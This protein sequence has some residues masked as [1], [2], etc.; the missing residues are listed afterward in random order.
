[1][2]A[3]VVLI[4]RILMIVSIYGFLGLAFLALWRE[5]KKTTEQQA[6]N[7]QPSL[8]LIIDGSENLQFSQPE[9]FIGRSANNDIQVIDETVSQHHARIFFQYD[10]WMLEDSR[11][12]NG[13]FLN[14]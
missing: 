7:A 8:S 5:L 12:T 14:G 4:I 10:H 11:S 9:I 1:M 2:S 3:I 13:T 6:A